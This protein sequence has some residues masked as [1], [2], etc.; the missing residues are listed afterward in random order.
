[1]SY[2]SIVTPRVQ[3]VTGQLDQWWTFRT[4]ALV[5]KER[6]FLSSC[7]NHYLLAHPA[8][9]KRRRLRR[10]HYFWVL[11]IELYIQFLERL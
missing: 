11:I 6:N 5:Y 9:Q 10:V 3:T 8:D 4:A 2:R 7:E 1:M